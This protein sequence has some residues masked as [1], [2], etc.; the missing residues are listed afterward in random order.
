MMQKKIALF[1]FHGDPMCFVHVLLNALDMQARGEDVALIIEGSATRLIQTL[2]EPDAPFAA[3]YRQVKDAGLIH[4]V[5]QA[6]ASKRGTLD[7]AKE[8]GLPLSNEMSGHPSM[9]AYLEQGYQ[10]VTF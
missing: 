3:L 7:A 2:N 8:Q 9:G 6:C 5:C 1:A 4:A 10:I